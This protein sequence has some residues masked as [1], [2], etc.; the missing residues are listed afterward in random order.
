VKVIDVGVRM[1]GRVKGAGGNKKV[2]GWDK[3]SEQCPGKKLTFFGSFLFF[4]CES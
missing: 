2:F 4:F 3:G 1:D